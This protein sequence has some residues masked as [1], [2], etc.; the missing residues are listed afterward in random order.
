MVDEAI[1]MKSNRA[2]ID[3]S[4]IASLPH[5]VGKRRYVIN[6]KNAP[7]GIESSQELKADSQKLIMNG[8]LIIIRNQSVYN[9]QGQL[10]Q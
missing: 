2:Y 3:M 10:I 6:S 4:Q 5:K 9:A 7:T 1:T 8:Q